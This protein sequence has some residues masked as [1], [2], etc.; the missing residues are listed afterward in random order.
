MGMY[1][2]TEKGSEKAGYEVSADAFLGCE[3]KDH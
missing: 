2:E 1:E 3:S